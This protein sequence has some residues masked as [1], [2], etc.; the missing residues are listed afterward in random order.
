MRSSARISKRRRTSAMR[1]CWRKSPSNAESTNG[2]KRRST[3]PRWR[4]RCAPWASRPCRPSSSSA[5]PASPG[6]IPPSSWRKPSA[7]LLRLGEVQAGLE[8]H[9]VDRQRRPA[10]AELERRK[11]LGAQSLHRG[12]ERLHDIDGHH[13]LA[14]ARAVHDAL[15]D[16]DAVAERHELLRA[17]LAGHAEHGFA[18][19]QAERDRR[20]ESVLIAPAL[21]DR[22]E[23]ALDGP[24]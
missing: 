1:P 2:R 18:G 6:P 5:G 24:R 12:A 22:A 13:D 20:R 19:V 7:R 16:A 14:G 4:K 15:G 17:K 10:V 3:S 11:L 21:A 8:H 23:I 9:A